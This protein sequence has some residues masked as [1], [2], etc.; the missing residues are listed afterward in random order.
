MKTLTLICDAWTLRIKQAN[1]SLDL[2]DD[3]RLNAY[4]K[5]DV[6]PRIDET[7]HLTGYPATN[8]NINDFTSYA[9]CFKGTYKVTNVI[10]KFDDSRV[11]NVY[12]EAERSVGELT[13]VTLLLDWIA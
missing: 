13:N 2:V 5:T 7:I 11:F 1:L 3:K 12:G 4:V 8:M 6:V 10:H 9:D